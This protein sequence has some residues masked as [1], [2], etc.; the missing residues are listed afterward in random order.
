MRIV[1]FLSLLLVVVQYD[2]VSQSMVTALAPSSHTANAAR[3]IGGV[4]NFA[5]VAP[6]QLPVY[7]INSGKLSH[8]IILNYSSQGYRTEDEASWVGLGFSLQVGG[9]ITRTVRGLPDEKTDGFFNGAPTANAVYSDAALMKKAANNQI[10]THPDLFYYNFDGYT[11]KFVFDRSGNVNMVPKRNFVFTRSP[12]LSFFKIVTENGTTY[13]FDVLETCKVTNSGYHTSLTTNYTTAWNLSYIQSAEHTGAIS[14]TYSA[15]PIVT[16]KN[17]LGDDITYKVNN[18]FSGLADYETIKTESH[19]YDVQYS[20]PVLDRIDF[21]NGYVLFQKMARSDS[22]FPGL[23][24]IELHHSDGT[25]F[26]S[27]NFNYAYFNVVSSNGSS[28]N[29]LRLRLDTYGD[30]PNALYKFEYAPQAAK[31]DNA[32]LRTSQD[33]WGFYNGRNQ[34][35]KIPRHLE[36]YSS[37]PNSTVDSYV[38]T[39]GQ[40]LSADLNATRMFVLTKMTNPVGGFTTFDYELNEA[41]F[42]YANPPVKKYGP[43]SISTSDPFTKGFTVPVGLDSRG[44]AATIKITSDCGLSDASQCGLGKPVALLSTCP[45]IQL[46]GPTSNSWECQYVNRVFEFYLSP[47]NYQLKVSGNS[48]KNFSVELYFYALDPAG[49]VTNKK[50]GGLRISKISTYQNDIDTHPII[51]KYLYN[52]DNGK[53]TGKLNADLSQDYQAQVVSSYV[54]NGQAIPGHPECLK[55]IL[56][57]TYGTSKISFGLSSNYS[58]GYSR[59]TEL[60][61]ANGENGKTEYYYYSADD[62]S[63]NDNLTINSWTRGQL[64]RV[65]AYRKSG[66]AYKKVKETIN[67]FDFTSYPYEKQIDG[68]SIGQLTQ[69]EIP[70]IGYTTTSFSTF[71]YKIMSDWSFVKKVTNIDYDDLEQP[72]S[73]ATDIVYDYTNLLPTTVK[74]DRSNSDKRLVTVT[75]YPG[76][77]GD[78]DSFIS[79]LKSYHIMN[80]PIETITYT[81]KN[82]GSGQFDIN[83]ISGKINIYKRGNNLLPN[84]VGIPDTQYNLLLPSGNPIPL[85]NF[86][87]TNAAKGVLPSGNSTLFAI[88]SGQYTP[89]TTIEDH[90]QLNARPTRILGQD[91]IRTSVLWGNYGNNVVSSASN[92]SMINFTSFELSGEAGGWSYSGTTLTAD[93]VNKAK[94]GKKYYDLSTGSITAYSLDAAKKYRMTFWAKGGS[95]TVSNA[96]AFNGET[97]VTDVN[98]WKFYSKIISGNTLTAISGAAG[99]FIDELSM[100]E[101]G[102]TVTTSVYDLRGVLSQSDANGKISTF[103]Y[104]ALGRPTIVKDQKGSVLKKYTYNVYKKPTN[105]SGIEARFSILSSGGIYTGKS[106]EFDAMNTDTNA[107]FDWDFGDGTILKNGGRIVNHIYTTATSF[108]VTLTVSYATLSTSN[109]TQQV[110]DVYPSPVVNPNWTAPTLIINSATTKLLPLPATTT[111]NATATIASGGTLP[112]DSYEWDIS[113]TNVPLDHFL[114]KT[115]SS[116]VTLAWTGGIPFYLHCRVKDSTGV[117]SQEAIL[118]YQ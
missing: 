117:Y 92:S 93:A 105:D 64:Q 71:E 16:T 66:T 3:E 90:D 17:L 14:F 52:D 55:G 50:A 45:F 82:L 10:D 42:T 24:T 54:P 18:Y 89:M 114:Y 103:E 96:V 53:T 99:V 12:D 51:K 116:S 101:E 65:V 115:T 49:T 30:D 109:Y 110:A 8:N 107:Q 76:N 80:A 57:A 22:S 7:T 33:H 6:I 85:T 31:V 108:I 61:G 37:V 102:S 112:I 41:D 104:D 15:N 98:G 44:A 59:I 2:V 19:S 11:G 91:G 118:V 94:T 23:Q 74:T 5:G 29:V 47:G 40:D 20:T 60:N 58:V 84:W 106:I 95:P 21:N 25:L 26:K 9:T 28:S 79:D 78:T 56:W 39:D 35:N 32:N 81:E 46:L 83:V 72:L 34:S 36:Y 86:T 87:F 111:I 97:G 70:C 38:L 1:I 73:E 63:H 43:I 62:Y 48:T 4:S 13:T 68:F 113:S 100:A 27:Y 69:E 75:N 88:P 77:Y 67:D